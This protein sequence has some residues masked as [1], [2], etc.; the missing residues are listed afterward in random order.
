MNKRELEYQLDKL[1]L[2][3]S[4]LEKDVRTILEAHNEFV[5]RTGNLINV[6]CEYL[7]V[8]IKFKKEVKE[9]MVYGDKIVKVP[10]LVKVA[11]DKVED[12]PTKK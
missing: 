3:T 1:Q 9:S 12:K 6:L 10:Y 8:N 7:G 4:S 2:R 11:E 5:E